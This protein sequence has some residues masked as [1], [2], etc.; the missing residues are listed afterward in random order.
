M[1]VRTQRDHPCSGG[2]ALATWGMKIRG[3]VAI[4]A[5][6]LAALWILPGCGKKNAVD[7]NAVRTTERRKDWVQMEDVTPAERAYLEYGRGVV[8]AVT[9]RAYAEFY[10]ELSEEARAR[11][12]LNQ[13]APERDEAAF[14]R[15]EK[16]PRLNV[17]AAEFNELMGRTEKHFGVP[18]IPL[19]LYLHTSDVAVLAGTKT[20]GLDAIDTMF[21]IG[22][23]P[24]SV[25]AASRKA[26]LRA[27]IEVELSDEELVEVAKTYN[28]TVEELQRDEDFKPYVTLKLVLVA[29]DGGKL[30]VGYFEFLPPSMMD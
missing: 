16:Q 14:A 15:L 21:A 5:V 19:D 25:S 24:A 4:A 9:N 20:D 17:T 18:L 7:E 27:K 10:A 1:P 2:E 22:N 12:S 11:M 30:R 29:G 23:M 6:S 3:T 8:Q 26:S 13:F 28:V